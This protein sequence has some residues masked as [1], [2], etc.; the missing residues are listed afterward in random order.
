[1]YFKLFFLLV[2]LA[3]TLDSQEMDSMED[4]D[5][6]AIE[7]MPSTEAMNI[8]VSN[9][10]EEDMESKPKESSK[11]E[12]KESSEEL[13][14][15]SKELSESTV[16]PIEAN[17]EKT[18]TIAIL[19]EEMENLMDQKVDSSSQPSIVQ[20]STAS[21]DLITSE[22]NGF[23]GNKSDVS[24]SCYGR[25][26]GQYADVM[27]ECRVFHL[28]YPYFNSTT[29]ELF[30]QRISFI[31]DND[32]VFDQKRFICVEN[33]TV[34][35]KCSDSEALYLQTNQEYL[36]R[37]Y[38]QNVSPIDEVKGQTPENVNNNRNWLSW[39]NPY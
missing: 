27:R 12:I 2:A 23:D 11:E 19:F 4:M 1:M 39:L 10:E 34:D 16:T 30:Y 35:H 26:F 36:I 7:S 29:D 17:E 22:Y 25:P 3:V 31:C 32:S 21:N 15:E 8:E 13:T 18:E 9:A 5:L 37:V 14:K 33:S 28:C 38:S 24:F 6:E 20:T